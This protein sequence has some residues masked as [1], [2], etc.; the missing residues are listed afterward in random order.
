VAVGVRVTDAEPVTLHG[1]R[2][3]H[4]PPVRDSDGLPGRPDVSR[5]RDLAADGHGAMNDPEWLAWER[6][7]RREKRNAMILAVLLWAVIIVLTGVA[8]VIVGFI[9][10]IFG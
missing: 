8:I 7:W 4:G 3:L 1:R 5:Q 9:L 6:R 10:A 2:R